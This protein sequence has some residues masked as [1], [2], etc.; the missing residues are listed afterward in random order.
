MD[1]Y[2]KL[3]RVY[4]S[5]R[6]SAKFTAA[7]NKE[8]KKDFIDS[9]G[10]MVAYCEKE[11]GKI[12]KF[13]IEADLDIVDK[14]I[15]DLKEYNKTLIY[16]DT[17]LARQIE[18]YLKRKEIAENIKREKNRAKEAG[19]EYEMDDESIHEYNNMIEDQKQQD[20]KVI[21]GEEDEE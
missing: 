1:G 5:L 20:F 3:S 13:K 4:D 6:K 7:Q 14:V 18:E 11:G 15:R 8:D 9:V 12:P 2:Q 10:Q 16:E 17:A 21:Y 19:E